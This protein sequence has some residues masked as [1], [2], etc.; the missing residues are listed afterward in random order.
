[1]AINNRKEQFQP[2]D[3]ISILS[4]EEPLFIVGGQAVNIWAFYY[5]D[6]TSE[7]QPFVSADI[8]LLGTR[9]TVASI[10]KKAGVE[11]VYFPMVPPTNEIGVIVAENNKNQKIII[12][13]LDSIYGITNDTL[14]KHIY[15][16]SIEN[17][18]IL[19]QVP[20]PIA[21]LKAKIANI[22][23]L[24]QKNRQDKK[25]VQV[26][27][28]LMP[29]YLASL[30]K[31]VNNGRIKEREMLDLL[32]FLLTIITTKKGVKV[33]EVLHINRNDLFLKINK[34]TSSKIVSFITKRLPRILK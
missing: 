29:G 8:D 16:L 7:L 22:S 14:N 19:V 1:M 33:F 28:K 2:K 11:P 9:K 24:S 31:S 13:V 30:Q 17:S 27:A 10:A 34:K 5:Y 6:Y 21:L 18:D 25:H 23:D 4:T 12:E 3:F 20:S 26:L 15:T 32:E